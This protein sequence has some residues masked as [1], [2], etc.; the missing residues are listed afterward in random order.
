MEA[1]A[2]AQVTMTSLAVT[3]GEC[4]LC[5]CRPEGALEVQLPLSY[6]SVFSPVRRDSLSSICS[7][8]SSLS[9]LGEDDIDIYL[10]SA[11][12]S[13]TTGDSLKVGDSYFYLFFH[14]RTY[15]HALVLSPFLT[16]L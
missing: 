4:G 11:T 7:S 15:L 13:S 1:M 3:F 9:S 2:Q 6:L 14:F 16:P 5:H 8:T 10:E 12:N